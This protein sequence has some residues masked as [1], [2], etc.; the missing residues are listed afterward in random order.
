L[1]ALPAEELSRL[2][3][4]IAGLIGLGGGERGLGNAEQGVG[5]VSTRC[6]PPLQDVGRLLAVTQGVAVQSS[7]K[8]RRAARFFQLERVSPGDRVHLLCCVEIRE[9]LRHLAE[10]RR[11]E[12]AVATRDGRLEGLIGAAQKGFRASGSLIGSCCV[13]VIGKRLRQVD[14]GKWFPDWVVGHPQ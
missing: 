9:S 6:T 14:Q 4:S 10:Q 11:R 13:A 2:G 5:Q 3:S 12:S 1:T 7:G 8:Q